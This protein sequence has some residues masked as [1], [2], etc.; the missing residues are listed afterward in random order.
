MALTAIKQ[1][2][3][4]RAADLTPKAFEALQVSWDSVI[5]VVPLHHAIQPVADNGNW[6]MPPTHQRLPEGQQRGSHS[7]LRR[8]ANDLKPTLPVPTATVGEPKEVEGLRPALTAVPS[9]RRGKSTKLDQSRLLGMQG[10][11]KLG[12]VGQH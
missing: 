11:P 10:Q 4:P 9:I 3:P 12:K 5:V 1:S 7:L 8:E 6:F 2:V